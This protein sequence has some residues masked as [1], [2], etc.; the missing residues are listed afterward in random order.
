MDLVSL[1]EGGGG[2][3]GDGN[4]LF[5]Q[6]HGE[7]AGH[8]L[9][10]ALHDPVPSDP[11]SLSLVQGHGDDRGLGHT[12]V[13]GLGEHQGRQLVQRLFQSLDRVLAGLAVHQVQR[14]RQHGLRFLLLSVAHDH[15][16]DVLQRRVPAW[17]DGHGLQRLPL[18]QLL[19]GGPSLGLCV[20]AMQEVYLGL[21]GGASEVSGR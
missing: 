7:V 15:V 6:T 19:R 12:R 10:G 14:L 1:V 2:A 20:R 11:V 4:E 18:L 8:A 17:R 13:E 9:V 16:G 5:A 3:L 21:A